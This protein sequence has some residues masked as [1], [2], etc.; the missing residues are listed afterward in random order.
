M[1]VNFIAYAIPIFFL[2][3]GI[4]AV[5]SRIYR[6]EYYNYHDSINDLSAGVLSQVYGIFLK[7]VFFGVYA[8]IYNNLRILT[9]PDTWWSWLLCF[10]GVDFFY[11]WFHRASHEVNFIWG[12]HVPHHQ[13]EEY[14]LTVALR[15]GS[16]QGAFSFA[17]YLPLAFLGFSPLAFIVCG[18]F[19]TIYQFWIHTKAIGKMGFLEIFLNTPSHHRVHHGINPKY[20]D[21][22]H[23]GTLIIWDK[24]FGTFQEEDEEPVYGTVSGLRSWNPLWANV[25][26]WYGMIKNTARFDGP[27]NK[28][29]YWVRPPGWT[30]NGMSVVPPVHPATFRKYRTYVPAWVNVYTLLNFILVVGG[31]LSLLFF[32]KMG[33]YELVGIVFFITWTLVN[34]GAMFESKPWLFASELGRLLVI[35]GLCVFLG[36]QNSQIFYLG[37]SAAGGFLAFFF[38]KHGGAQRVQTS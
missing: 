31:T 9:I 35:G 24:M 33:L 11:Y 34:L 15:Q 13:S 21:R 28:I 22:N 20:I 10:L 8:Y 32:P 5:F 17:F 14:N 16:V 36:M 1:E 27:W 18:Q 26:H 4:E 25:E 30:P 7:A 2:L 12:S 3:I 19:N 29:Q 38:W 6:K 23:G 37:A